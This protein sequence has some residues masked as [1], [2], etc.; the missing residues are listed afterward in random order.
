M[1]QISILT[2]G[3]SATNAIIHL[4]K[5]GVQLDTS[6]PKL[7]RLQ[8]SHGDETL[9]DRVDIVQAVGS[10][11]NVALACTK[12]QLQS[13]VL[14]C[15]GDDAAGSNM[16]R[17][18]Q[19]HQV[20]TDAI[21]TA[22]HTKTNY[23]YT[24]SYDKEPTTLVRYEPFT[25]TWQSPATPPDWIFLGEL[26]TQQPAIYN[27]LLQY[28]QANPTVQ[29]AFSP[30]TTQL[31]QPAELLTALY[32]RTNLLV[33]NTSI[34]NAIAPNH[35]TIEAQC[36]ALHKLGIDTII[37]TDGANPLHTSSDQG[38]ISLPA[39]PATAKIIDRTGAGDAF[40][41]TV[42]A[43]LAQGSDLTTAAQHA[44]I[45]SMNVCQHIGPHAGL[46]TNEG[47][48]K[49]FAA[50]PAEFT[51]TVIAQPKELSIEEVAAKLVASPK[52]IFAADES[53]GSIE[54]RFAEFA[55]PFSEENR[56]LYRQ[57]FFTTP[58][59][60]EY[61][62]GVILFDETARQQA[63]DGTPFVE[64]LEKR[65]IIPG[66]KVDTGLVALPNFPGET[67]TSGLDGLPARLAEYRNMGLRFAKWRAAFVIDGDNGTLPSNGAIAANIHALARY[68]LECQH[69]DIVPIIEPEIVHAG[70][71]N[72]ET[73]RQVTA[74]VL[75]ALFDE[76]ALFKVNHKALLLKTSM[77]LAGSQQA[78]TPPH[79]VAAATVDTLRAHVPHDVA[80]VVFLSGGQG[81]EQ[82]T[83][84]LRAINQR[85][86]Q[87]WPLTFSYARALQEPAIA[88]WK[89]DNAN[90]HAAQHAFLARVEAN[91]YAAARPNG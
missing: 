40:V 76:I 58:H 18:L 26:T 34:A 8:L 66:I 6:D 81:V 65:G 42:I 51:P 49:L 2:I 1:K 73:C 43:K 25:Y 14:T 9:Y 91:S 36:E 20:A 30:S 4:Q 33:V 52:G 71:F 86:R 85:G 32:A 80:G 70:N 24:L 74:K 72:L 27:D 68:A 29:F 28:L 56:R 15:I 60:E 54:K 55:I 11:P 17:Y 84:N 64:L 23:H 67:V 79:E 5:N 83:E 35:T 88:L 7:H 39:Y 57:L 87:P 69:A 48:D 45:N 38:I 77:V 44:A 31:S 53:G 37:I 3:D 75:D 50:A 41:A 13:A 89:G 47:I 10:A 82:A 78:I 46:L 62:S 90:T 19:S 63:D 21:T 22:P 12:L 59:I 61:V 16:V